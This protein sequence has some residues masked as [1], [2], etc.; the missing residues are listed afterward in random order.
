MREDS[1]LALEEALYDRLGPVA[2]REAWLWRWH[3]FALVMGTAALCGL[4]LGFLDDR[5]GWGGPGWWVLLGLGVVA[6]MVLA[7]WRVEQRV[8]DLRALAAQI[9]HAHPD[10]RALL[11]TAIAQAPSESDGRFGYLQEQVLREAVSQ[12]A[13][14]A[15]TRA[16]PTR[17]LWGAGLG[18]GLGAAALLF[19]AGRSLLPEMPA[20]F[21][22]EFGLSVQ[23][24]DTEVEKGTA[25]TVLARFGRTVPSRA[26]LL[27]RPRGKAPVRLGMTRN[28]A[29]PVFAA[30]TAVGDG[31]VDYQIEYGGRRSKRFRITSFVLPELERMDARI[32]Y[33]RQPTVPAKDLQDIHQVS[34]A[35][36][37]RVAL[38]LR[39]NKPVAEAHLVGDDGTVVN[40]AP[41]GG[42]GEVQTVSLDPDRTRHYEVQLFDE[43]RRT[44]RTPPRL[45]IEVHG[46]AAPKIALSFPGHDVRVSPLEELT[47]EAKVSDD[48]GLVG[49]GV[50]YALAGKPP[51][52]LS[53]GGGPNVRTE[54]ARTIISLE[55][56]K[57]EPDDLLSYHFWA[58]DLAGNGD[59]RRVWSDMYFAEVRPFEER[60]QEGPSDSGGAAAAARGQP[61]DDLARREKEIINATWRLEREEREGVPAPELKNDIEVVRK[62][63]MEIKDAAE[64]VRQQAVRGEV[65]TTLDEAIASMVRAHGQLPVNLATA[66]EAEQ[67]AYASLL[68][69]RLR[70][71]AVARGKSGGG[72]AGE[73]G[74]RSLDE[75][76]LKQKENRYET[77]S[78]ATAQAEDQPAREDRQVLNRLRDLAE[79]QKTLTDR[80]KELQVAL[81]QATPEEREELQRR[82]KRL[83]E[84]QQEMLSDLDDL[85]ERMDRPENRS[86]LAEARSGLESTRAR[87]AETSEA[88]ARGETGRA[89]GA[90]T[91]TERALDRMRE[92]LQR[93]VSRA[94][95]DEMRDLRTE[96][97]RLAQ[98]QESLGGAIRQ[99]ADPKRPPGTP[100]ESRRL[101]Q[102]LRGQKQG[103]SAL[104]DRLRRITEETETS[105]PLLSR[106]LYDALR[107][108]KMDGV[109]KSLDRMSDLMDHSFGPQAATE[110]PK[111]REAV[112]SLEKGVG[113][114]AKGVL[115]DDAEALRLAQSELDSLL[116]EARRGGAIA[117]SPQGGQPPPNL[118]R[119]RG[120]GGV[121]GGPPSSSNAPSSASPITG[122]NFR[123]WAD[124]LR[125]VQE[126]LGEPAL[127]TDAARVLD[128]ARAL[129]GEARRHAEAPQWSV[130][131]TEIV[132][133]LTELRDRVNEELRRVQPDKDKLAPID[134]DPVPSR[135]SELVRRYYK[136][137]SRE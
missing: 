129:R 116:E 123:A 81:Q 53:L 54:T 47:L 111:V 13:P 36:G 20:L 136:S 97:R 3:S 86:R 133:P 135:Y 4:L 103:V 57:A 19:V 91:R 96:A 12:A 126:L 73:Q 124:R 69:L 85:M 34:V 32:V 127:R 67:S 18:F 87:A 92:D 39:L 104:L 48:V 90:G 24:G 46:N 27:V 58:E 75:L 105:A 137:L 16:I 99:T 122:E 45:T 55:D 112:T 100:T 51:R 98:Q 82:L 35:E 113:E 21:P 94:L 88:L 50:S 41:S 114:A 59:R 64:V 61:G 60:Y 72:G 26:S 68:K 76:E 44:N 117:S 70:E 65:K 40:L 109:E 110:E 134:R 29:D 15:W 107:K 25:V 121:G 7:Y 83:R 66:L 28:L 14:G 2:R 1:P 42:R 9:E 131:E 62:G 80:I 125:D 56:L 43:R 119:A 84:E 93:K 130:L 23:P 108:A 101:A 95:A 132:R 128:R 74:D 115:G 17:R 77:R 38:S 30:S 49:Y 6:A 8:P 78:E 33:P 102:A 106:K 120:A 118:P 31:I 10:L 89:V 63:Q 11:L 79:R 71:H 22:D 52:E 37:A 5:F